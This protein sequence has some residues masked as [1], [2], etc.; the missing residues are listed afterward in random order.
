MKFGVESFRS[1]LVQLGSL[2]ADDTQSLIIDNTDGV[3]D[4]RG[5]TFGDIN[6]YMNG[7]LFRLEDD[8]DA[9][10]RIS[11]GDLDGILNSTQF[12]LNDV[13]ETINLKADN[14]TTL[15]GTAYSYTMPTSTPASGDSL[16]RA[17][18][19][20]QGNSSFK[21]V[22][23]GDF[24]TINTTGNI[25]PYD[26]IVEVIQGITVHLP[27]PSPTYQ[28]KIY[29]IIA[30]GTVSVGTPSTIDV[31][32]GGSTIELGA[33][34]TLDNAFEVYTLTCNGSQWIVLNNKP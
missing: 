9:V 3:D 17:P 14:G 10:S 6:G 27:A 29:H 11:F 16:D 32:D 18:V 24:R 5:V 13:A 28:G 33:S 20:R 12:T 15:S 30:G 23:D 22:N 21:V 25:L 26:D 2:G 31:V 34:L 4:I 8:A 1:Y 19:W 7:A